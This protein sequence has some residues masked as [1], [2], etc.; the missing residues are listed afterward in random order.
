MADAKIWTAAE[1]EELEPNEHRR[2]FNERVVTDLAEVSPEFL[3]RARSAAR[4]LLEA[5]GV[6]G[7]P[8]G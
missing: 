5:R 2:V 3:A 7:K 8:V 4:A 1:L 6:L